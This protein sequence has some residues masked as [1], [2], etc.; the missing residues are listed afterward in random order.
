MVLNALYGNVNALVM[1]CFESKQPRQAALQRA[2]PVLGFKNEDEVAQGT[3]N[4]LCV[5]AS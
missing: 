2:G 3:Y 1:K 5:G 4:V